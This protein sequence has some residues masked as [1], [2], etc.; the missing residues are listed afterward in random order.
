M[1]TPTPSPTPSN[2]NQ[3]HYICLFVAVVAAIGAINWG[4]I[5]AF[6]INFVEQLLGADTANIV[7]IVVGVCGL[8]TLYC[9][10]EWSQ[11]DSFGK[12]KSN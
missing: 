6:K 10:Y 5:G 4:T 11:K 9:Q 12:I 7:Y 2:V 3:M 1:S 8:V